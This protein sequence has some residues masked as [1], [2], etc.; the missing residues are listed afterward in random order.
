MTVQ[1]INESEYDHGFWQ[2]NKFIKFADPVVYALTNREEEKV[3][4][5]RI[6]AFVEALEGQEEISIDYESNLETALT[7]LGDGS[8]ITIV[9]GWMDR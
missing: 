5:T 4:D 7:K 3:R 8:I 1:S 2:D 9:H 6:S